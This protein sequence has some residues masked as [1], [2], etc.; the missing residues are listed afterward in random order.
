MVYSGKIMTWEMKAE[1]KQNDSK[2]KDEAL[3]H[4]LVQSSSRDLIFNEFL[5]RII[6]HKYLDYCCFFDFSIRYSGGS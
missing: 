1:P 6:N 2:T 5:F 3:V 4:I